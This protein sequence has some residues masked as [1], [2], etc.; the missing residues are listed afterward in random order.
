M[1]A[2][3]FLSAF[4]EVLERIETTQTESIHTAA[5]W[6]A[7]A[8]MAD[9]FGVLFGSGHSFIPT[10]DVYPRIGSFPGW[11]PIHELSTSYVSRVSGDIGLRQS[12]FLEKIEGFGK[13]ILENYALQPPDVMV[14]I[15]NSGVNTMGVEVAL[16]AKKR[17]LK[18]I[19]V[20]SMSHSVD[21]KSFHSS[22]KRL[23]EAV[24]LTLDNCVP[25]G[26]ALVE[27]PGFPARVASASTIADCILLQSVA[28]ETAQ[29]LSEH[30]Y[31][32]PVFPSHN[33]KMSREESEA[34]DRLIERFYEE[35]ARRVRKVLR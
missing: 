9:R 18:T 31:I 30:G 14:V 25:K 6:V 20:T 5:G 2:N 1:S 33:E 32:P 26:D 7:E 24:D 35:D 3:K 29:I 12:L 11:L 34:A 28:A 17:G 13:L 16:E 4:R 8:I 19:G 10:M 21:G 23:F 22:G 27:I 15:S